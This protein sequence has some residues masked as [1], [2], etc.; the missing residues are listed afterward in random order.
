[1]NELQDLFLDELADLL[2]AENLLVKALPK[3]AKSA[4]EP[5]LKKAF[6]THT[7]ETKKQVA[8][9]KGVFASFGEKVKSKK[10]MAMTG[11]IEE[12]A[13]IIEEWK[14]SPA[15]DA[16]LISAA[17]KAE[18]YEIASYGCLCTWAKLLGNKKALTLLKQTINEEELTDKKLSQIAESVANLEAEQPEE[19]PRKKSGSRKKTAKK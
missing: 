6:Q 10:C 18:H 16:A 14:D 4:K 9:I 5:A 15:G 17:Q 11:L 19:Q 12:G 13:E 8:R 3:M 2:Y 7:E 1:M